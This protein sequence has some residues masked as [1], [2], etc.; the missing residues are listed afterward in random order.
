M[1]NL[2]YLF[3]PRPGPLPPHDVHLQLALMGLFAAGLG[4]SI[5]WSCFRRASLPMWR[6]V[7]SEIPLSLLVLGLMAARLLEIPYLSMRVLF[8]GATFVCLGGW[9][10]YI[11]ARGHQTGFLRR[12]LGLVTF[13]WKEAQAP[14]SLSATC[15]LLALHLV[16]SMVLAAHL[17]RSYWWMAALFLL[18]LSPQ[19]ILSV[20]T[21]KWI[22]Y[23]EALTPLCVAYLAAVSHRLCA[24]LLTQPL[25]LYDG[26]TYPEPFSSLLNIEAIFFASV[27]YVLLCQGYLLVLRW[28]RLDKYR[29]YVGAALMSAALI[30]AGAEYFRHRTHGVTANDPFAYAQMAVDIAQQGHPVHRFELFPRISNLGISW[31]PVVHYGYQV[32][33]PP[34]RGDGSTATD[35][36][37]GWPVILSVWYLLLGEEGLYVANPVVSL[38]CLGGVLALVAE[39]LYDR[40]WDERLLGGA[41]AAFSLATS[42]EHIDRL[43]V[44]MADASTQLF[45]VLTL[46]LILRGMR[47]RHRLYAVLAGLSLGWAFFIRH[48]QLV[49]GLCAVVAVL[50]LGRHKLSLK[51]RWEFLG[52]FGLAAFLLA[53]PDLLYHQFAFGHFLTPESTE[54]DLFSLINVPAT[55]RLMWQRFLSGNEF[56]YLSPLVVY[57]AVRTYMERRGQFL[58]LLVAVLG[59]LLMHLPYEALRLRDLLS[60]FPVLLAWCGCGVADLWR[61][62]QVRPEAV[63]YGRYALSVAVLLALLLVPVLRTWPILPRPRGSYRASFGYVSAEE[64]R[65]F[66]LL[67]EYAVEPCVVGSSLNGGP[68]DLYAGREAFRPAFWTE[69]EVDVFFGQM[70]SEGTAVYILDDGEAVRPS[71]NHAEAHYK[72]VGLVRLAVPIFGDPD[73]VSGVLYQIKPRSEVSR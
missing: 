16:G 59:I 3:D 32:R 45:T 26:F 62:V 50:A 60:L 6:I 61:R 30:W 28:N 14:A 5:F 41:F 34:L 27:I 71:L 7:L 25:P 52:L 8:Y 55:A 46:F 72:V 17:G 20:W 38:L 22:L 44:P 42:Y 11:A 1:L 54:L 12:Q 29:F 39:V 2:A 13:S 9:V 64:R 48:T 51:E 63:S 4:A 53:V 68:I 73:R 36:P 23:L 21:R 49:L 56:G 58:I 33:V 66:D 67:A 10:A 70:F 18:L 47:G 57:G 40:P 65:A 35:W 19:L 37:A 15:T 24:K 69:E 31:W 43:L